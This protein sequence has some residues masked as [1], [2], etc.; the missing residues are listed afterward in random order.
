MTD[1][2]QDFARGNLFTWAHLEMLLR[3]FKGYVV[4]SGY[5]ITAQGSPDNTVAVAAGSSLFAGATVSRSAG[6]VTIAACSETQ[7]RIDILYAKN[8][9]S[10][11]VHQGDDAAISDPLGNSSWKEYIQPYIKAS[12]TAGA[13]LGAI[14]VRPRAGTVPV[15]ETADIWSWGPLGSAALGLTLATTVGD[16]GSETALVH[17][18]GI[19]AGLN[20]KISHALATAASDFLVAS[21]SGTFVKKTLAETQKILDPWIQETNFTARPPSTSTITM[22]ADMTGTI[23]VGMG[24]KYTWNGNTYYGYVSAIA[25]NLLTIAGAPVSTSYD[26]T[27]LYWCRPERVIQVDF[28]VSGKFADAANT[29]LLNSDVNTAFEWNLGKAYC[30][31]IRHKVKTDDSGANQPRVTISIAGA[32][33]GTDNT[34][35][36]QAVAETWTSTVVGINPS[37][38]DINPDEA[39]EVVTDAN[40]SNDNAENLTVSAIFVLE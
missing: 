12:I 10:V 24:L 9:G 40:G 33:V 21:G 36:G 18:Q 39:I 6:N 28:F 20:A 17:E 15:I 38:Y 8:D 4:L 32:V 11:G 31:L 25:S 26:V 7:Y 13:I 14:L 22:T 29:A 23:K 3:M 35:A 27:A 1:I 2:S 19:R 16:P 37:N 34:N 30:V 5:A